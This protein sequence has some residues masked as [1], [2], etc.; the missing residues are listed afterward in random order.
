MKK[1]WSNLKITINLKPRCEAFIHLTRMKHQN[2]NPMNRNLLHY[3][4][5][6]VVVNRCDE[7]KWQYNLINTEI[8]SNPLTENDNCIS[9]LKAHNIGAIKRNNDYSQAKQ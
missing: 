7:F 2:Y 8:R 4:C 5:R 6:K 9:V 1:Y 3:K